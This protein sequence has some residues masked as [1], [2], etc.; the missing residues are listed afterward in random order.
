MT[1]ETEPTR[2]RSFW[3]RPRIR[4]VALSLVIVLSSAAVLCHFR[5]HLL[6]KYKSLTS[7]RTVRPIPVSPI[8]AVG[9][10]SGWYRCRIGPLSLCIP[11]DLIEHGERISVFGGLALKGDHLLIGMQAMP[12]LGNADFVKDVEKGFRLQFPRRKW[13]SYAHLEAE[14]FRASA[15]D[16]RWSMSPD[17]VRDFTLW[18]TSAATGVPRDCTFVETRFDAHIEGI[19]GFFEKEDTARFSWMLTDGTSGGLILFTS[20]DGRLNPDVV[21]EICQSFECN[22]PLPEKWSKEDLQQALDT[23]EAVRIE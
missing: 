23:M 5:Y 19:L 20:P 14:L 3:R 12:V 15:D 4:T 8:P 2:Q 18:M 7:L 9:P 16:F 13:E 6:W 21:R 11:A 10:T 17:E 1:T 22:G